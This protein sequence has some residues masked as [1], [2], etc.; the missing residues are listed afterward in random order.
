LLAALSQNK[1]S[2]KCMYRNKHPDG[3]HHAAASTLDDNIPNSPIRWVGSRH[4]VMMSVQ[5]CADT[6]SLS[7]GVDV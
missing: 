5:H 6:S 3:C 4:A 7:H 1:L 2:R